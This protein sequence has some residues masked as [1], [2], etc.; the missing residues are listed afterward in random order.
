M[1]SGGSWRWGSRWRWRCCWR[2]R[3]RRG[4]GSTRSPSAA[5]TSAPTPT[6]PTPP[7][8]P[9]S[10]PTASA[11][12]RP[13]ATPSTASHLKSLTRDG[14]GTVTG[15]RFAR[16][17]WTAPPGTGIT[18]VRG[19][20]WHAL[21]DGLEQR[22][23]VGQLRR[24][25]RAVRQ[26]PP[27][28]DIAPR[29][30]VAGFATPMAGASKT[31][32]SAPAPKAS[33]ARWTPGS[34]SALRALTITLE[35]GPRPGAGI[36]GDLLAG[37]WRRGG[38]AALIWGADIGAG[39]R[40]GE[41][42]PRRRPRRPHRVPLRDG[43]DRRRVAGDADAALP[44]RRRRQPERSPPPPSAT[45]RTRSP[46]RHR[47]RRQRR[48]RRSLPGPDRQ[49]PAR[50]PA[51]AG[52]RRRRG[53]A[54]G[55]TT[56]TSAG[57]TPTRA[58]PARSP[59][60]AGG[61]TG[62]GGFDTGVKFAAGRDRT[63][64]PTSTS[65][66]PGAY[67]L[68]LWLR[69]E[70][71]NEAPATRGRRAAALRRRAAR[72]SP[73]AGRGRA[74]ARAG[75]GRGQRRRLRPGAGP[76]LLPPR[77][78]R[79][80]ERAADQAGARRA[81]AGARLRRAAARTSAPAP[82]SSGPTPP[83]R[84]GN[85]AIDRPRADGTEM[86][87]SRAEAVP[88]AR[89][90]SP[91]ARRRRACSPGCGGG[92]GRRRGADRPLRGA[93]P[94]QR[95]PHPGRRRRARRPRAAGR[96]PAL[97]RRPRRPDGGDRHDRRA[98]RLRAA[99]AARSLASRRGRLRRRRRA[100]ARA[101][102]GPLELRVRAGVSLRAAAAELRTGETLRLSGR[103]AAAAPRSRAAASWSRSSTWSRRRI[104]GG[105]SLVTRTDHQRA[106]PRPLPLPLRQRRRPRSACGRR[107]WRRSAGPTPPAPRAR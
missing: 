106:L 60:P 85:T 2:W 102:G 66:A 45:A 75:R 44:D 25:L 69:D 59:A 88:A 29:E 52:A 92:H 9:S 39:I 93:G 10:A 42:H 94:A 3:R 4:R 37:G 80:L 22:L 28:T 27:T 73:S 48:L 13:A 76:D 61:S 47:L 100:R 72:A 74:A 21:H 46:L 63:A 38:Q 101:A 67:S 17:R 84:A 95:P 79:A 51:L 6:G 57:P 30:F 64:S 103:S 32:C 5:G 87:A 107:P 68:A 81:P 77:R 49:Q 98:R 15:T 16:W 55:R 24:R 33:G 56:S 34:W 23:G 41:T 104:A 89:R 82:T 86:D 8:A 14:Q 58:R 96:R 105:R 36:G 1:E 62:P 12:R 71:G 31:A 11:C 78:L 54:A 18:Q 7:A 97:A 70:A 35:D 53:L 40:F 99:P 65:P 20:W 26:S 19:T 90:R 43:A 83:T 50:P 91:R